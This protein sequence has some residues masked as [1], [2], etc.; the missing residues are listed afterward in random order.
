[1]VVTDPILVPGLRTGSLNAS[2]EPF[3]DKKTKGV[4]D[5]LSGDGADFGPHTLGD[6]VRRA[7]RP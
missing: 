1:M 7:M 2:N 6:I 4:V 5:R 3:L